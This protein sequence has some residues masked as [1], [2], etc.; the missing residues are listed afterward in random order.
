MMR[1]RLTGLAAVTGFVATLIFASAELSAVP[2]TTKVEMVVQFNGKEQKVV[3]ELDEVSAPQTC[4]NFRKLCTNGFYDGTLFHRVIPNYIVQAGDPL[5]KDPA[6]RGMWGTGGPGYTVRPELGK[7]HVKGAL[8]MARLGD[9]VNPGKESS[10]SQFYVALDKIDSLD[11]EYTVFG[12]VVSG[13]E[14]LVAIGNAPSDQNNT[15][16]DQIVIK[17]ARVIGENPQ[18]GGEADVPLPPIPDLT[19]TTPAPAPPVTAVETPAPRPPPVAPAPAP[20]PA[21]VAENTGVRDITPRGNSASVIGGEPAVEAPSRLDPNAPAPQ[22]ATKK[23][24]KKES[25][26][27]KFLKRFW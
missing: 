12:N 21:P 15:P 19:N 14:T 10:G 7:S 6:K 25:G 13:I 18:P 11:G 1:L 22:G 8:A 5:S 20:A 3:F 26:F 9:A 16:I 17:S 2:L 27:T 4:A 23:P 24:S